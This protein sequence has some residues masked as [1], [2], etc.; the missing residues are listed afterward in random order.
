MATRAARRDLE[1]P[2]EAAVRS[3]RH[4]RARTVTRMTG[5]LPYPNADAPSEEL[6]SRC[7]HCGLC[8]PSCPTFAVLGVETDSPR[9]RIRLM[10]TVWEGRVSADAP[11][12]EKHI[13]QCLDC[14]ACETACPSGVEYG[15]LVEA[16]RSQ[17]LAVR[18]PSAIERAIG[19][20]R[21]RGATSPPSRASR[22]KRSS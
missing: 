13:G 18:R 11:S 14:R 21:S 17:I 7:V 15:K 5:I 4:P 6:I 1:A 3:R 19:P 2:P 20:A 8:L 9:G 22:S 16:A 12:F 10:K